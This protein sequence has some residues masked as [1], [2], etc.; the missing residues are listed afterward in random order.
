MSDHDTIHIRY[1]VL[2]EKYDDLKEELKA[3]R[4]KKYLQ[5]PAFDNWNDFYEL[6]E[7]EETKDILKWMKYKFPFGFKVGTKYIH[8]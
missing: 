7:A 4:E 8:K 5:I 3:E 6:A 2:T 1:A